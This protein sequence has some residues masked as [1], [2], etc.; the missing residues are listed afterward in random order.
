MEQPKDI[1][2]EKWKKN[3]RERFKIHENYEKVKNEMI[4]E[5]LKKLKKVKDE[6]TGKHIDLDKEFFQFQLSKYGEEYEKKLVQ[7]VDTSEQKLVQLVNTSEQKLKKLM[8][9]NEKELIESIKE[10]S[11]SINVDLNDEFIEFRN[12]NDTGKKRK[13]RLKKSKRKKL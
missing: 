13:R 10:F 6:I 11:E 3:I 5:H 2:K 8:D 9:D 4:R 7:L 12:K 1:I